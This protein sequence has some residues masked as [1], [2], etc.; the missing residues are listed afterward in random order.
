MIDLAAPSSYVPERP[1]AVW[2]ELRRAD[3]LHWQERAGAPGFHSVTRYDHA[4]E[5]L[6]DGVVF[7]SE[8]GMTLDSARGRRDPASGLMIELTDRPRHS[9]LRR[10]VSAVLTP[11]YL[12]G[13]EGTIRAR[14]RCLVDAAV[15]SGEVDFAGAVAAPLPSA[16][17]GLAL[18]LPESDWGMVSD[19]ASRAICGTGAD[20]DGADAEADLAA[21]RRMSE[22]ANG[23]LL[24]YFLRAVE[25]EVAVA[26]DGLVRLLL[27]AEVEG[28]RLTDDEVVLN[29][30]NLAIGGNETTRNA[31]ASAA[32]L[33]ARH[34]EAWER[35]RRDPEALRNGLEEVLR[36]ATP[37]MHLVRTVTRPA[38]LGRTELR[39]GDT[40]C[41]WLA[42]ANRDERVFADPDAFSVDRQPNP[43]LAFSL[44]PHFCLG[45][46]LAR[47]ELRT[48]LEELAARVREIALLEP[49]RLRASN[50]I[51]TIDR[52]PVALA[53]V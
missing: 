29:C 25:G 4:R 30:L 33:F 8:W 22:A 23:R 16:T 38:A 3:R 17:I 44:G 52:L 6:G 49:P 34:P 47:L 31:A 35:V 18:G 24:R 39:E 15:R 43:H 42:S 26:P 53:A 1:L 9:R 5:V 41:V 48:A 40:V 46:A 19:L 50:F 32:L 10:V 51:T 27:D 12:A 7:S 2:A 21:R 36:H 13:L 20:G 45:S 37:A 14:V 11:R 28:E